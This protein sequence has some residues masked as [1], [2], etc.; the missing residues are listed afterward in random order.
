[1][2]TRPTASDSHS[3]SG[4][5]TFNRMFSLPG[6]AVSGVVVTLP[7]TSIHVDEMRDSRLLL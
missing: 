7:I 3:I 2:V 4:P 6:P 1:M 5:M